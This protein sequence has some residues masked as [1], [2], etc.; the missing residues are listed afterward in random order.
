MPS[1]NALVSL[2]VKIGFSND[3]NNNNNMGYGAAEDHDVIRR[4]GFYQNFNFIEKLR[5]L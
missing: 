3:N 2:R 4:L 5:K 1:I